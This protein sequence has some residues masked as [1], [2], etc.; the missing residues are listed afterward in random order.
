MYIRKIQQDL[1]VKM[2]TT[3]QRLACA[4]TIV[5]LLIHQTSRSTHSPDKFILYVS[6]LFLDSTV[7]QTLEYSS[8]RLNRPAWVCWGRGVLCMRI[9]QCPTWRQWSNE[10]RPGVSHSACLAST[11]P[12]NTT[13]Q[14][15]TVPP[16]LCSRHRSYL[17]QSHCLQTIHQPLLEI[18]IR[19]NFSLGPRI[20]KNKFR[21]FKFKA[22]ILWDYSSCIGCNTTRN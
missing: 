7:M 4:H 22:G 6:V 10:P 14:Q 5:L 18:Y 19:S 1:P 16:P 9:A 15:A 12:P 17:E 8:I 13:C 3:I 20:E 2:V 11:M 21:M